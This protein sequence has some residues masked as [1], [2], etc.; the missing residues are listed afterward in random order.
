MNQLH[1]FMKI[2]AF[3]LV[4]VCLGTASVA[5]QSDVRMQISGQETYVGM[6][7]TL[8]IQV[9][10][11]SKAEAPEFPNIDGLDIRSSGMPSRNSSVTILNGR[12]SES[13]SVTYSF[14]FTP[15]REGQFEI[16]SIAIQTA[17]GTRRT[18]PFR[19]SATK[20]ET[21]D[22]M[23]A[24]VA[25]QQED[26]YV[27][28]PI[29]LTLRVWLKPFRD[30][31]HQLT[32]SAG[33]MWR[34]IG[35][36][37]QWGPFTETLEKMAADGKSL[38]GRE[39][40]RQDN[41][42]VERSYY[43]YEI[44]A[45]F[46]PKR[47]GQIE[48]E[49]V[50]V[51]AQYPT[52]LGQSR[53]PFASFFRDSPFSGRSPFGG[54]S[55][56][57]NGSPFG[58]MFED[59]FFSGRASPFGR[60]LAVTATRPIVVTPEVAPINVVPIPDDGRPADYRGAVG[61]YEMIT[62]VTPTNVKAGDPITLKIGIR[63]TGP[64]ELVQA[65]PLAQI[66]SLAAD[67]KVSDEP[68]AGVVQ[69]DIKVFT[70][71]IRPRREG[72]AQVPSVPFSFFNPELEEFVTVHSEPVAIEVSKAEKLALD[73]IVGSGGGQRSL[74]PGDR[75]V[76]SAPVL[77]NLA[78]KQLLTNQTATPNFFLWFWI[79]LS[80]AIF[81]GTLLVARHR[82]R[83]FP[84]NETRA[85]FRKIKRAKE[86]RCVGT[87]ILDLIANKCGRPTNLT[88]VEATNEISEQVDSQTLTELEG[89][90]TSCETAAFSGDDSISL[91]QTKQ[92]ARSLAAKL[93]RIHL[94]S[95][96]KPEVQR[97]RRR[98][99]DL[100]LASVFIFL[101]SIS[102]WSASSS[103][104]NKTGIAISSASQTVALDET[105]KVILLDEANA[106]YQRGMTSKV[107]DAAEA[108][109]AFAKAANKYQLLV[110]SGVQNAGLFFNLGNAYLQSDS[111]GRAIANFERAK[112]LRP[113]DSRIHRNLEFA[114]SL[115]DNSAA[116]ERV[117]AGVNIRFV[118]G[119]LSS[120]P[121]SVWL[122]PLSIGW[123][124][125]CLACCIRLSR[126]K[127]R[128]RYLA[129][130]AMVLVLA[131]SSLIIWSGSQSKDSAMAVVV[132][133]EV[134]VYQGSSEAFPQ[135]PNTS[136]REGETVQVIQRR[137]DW[138]QIRSATGDQGWAKAEMLEQV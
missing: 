102:L 87:A 45:T 27:G 3:A 11:D 132:V 131:A 20:S 107:T 128:V 68:L 78:G 89:L 95:F 83:W 118:L 35:Q 62:R 48:M 98:V 8:Y 85:T 28:Q 9:E 33:D 109:A 38:R 73:A 113:F 110:G 69:D 91:D 94:N 117:T 16:P 79:F 60:S 122:T 129:V 39:V 111:V 56:L 103:Q 121:S 126:P 77:A 30:K 61:L 112:L 134:P 104:A 14:Q 50:Q 99:R 116:D 37:S 136:M 88:R 5:A 6:P 57:G 105:Q 22:L 66:P 42:G 31:Q 24:E 36:N 86:T 29:D 70:T 100:A 106:E 18:S 84:K 71:T 76:S 90:L 59:D 138:L 55:P 63:G 32:M 67:F 26:L 51:V 114:N 127:F 93:S 41:E 133:E 96:G 75:P 52:K 119:G 58:S 47:A 101:V 125:L 23:F 21:G 19:I 1:R 130:P 72:I 15:R 49:D 74:S 40:L 54:M 13:Q 81:L 44:V 7:V 53:D 123:V 82:N 92:Q 64:M 137:G 135:L 43:L 46:Y 65:P 17:D 80:P 97:S 4:I 124:A 34:M 108:N 2:L 10:G 25:G 12:R 115:V 120:L